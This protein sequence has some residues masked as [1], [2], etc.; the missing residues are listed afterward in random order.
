[1]SQ[2]LLSPITLNTLS[3]TLKA[4]L[5]IGLLGVSSISAAVATWQ[6]KNQ[7]EN[8]KTKEIL[9]PIKNVFTN[10]IPNFLNAEI[11]DGGK[12]IFKAYKDWKDKIPVEAFSTS[13]PVIDKLQKWRA[14][15]SSEIKTAINNSS[16]NT[17]LLEEINYYIFEIGNIILEII[18]HIQTILMDTLKQT[19]KSD[20]T[21]GLIS[22]QKIETIIKDSNF[23]QMSSS[24]AE[25]A[26]KLTET[27]SQINQEQIDTAVN[28]LK[29]L[30]QND[31]SS[32]LQNT[33]TNSEEIKNNQSDYENNPEEL[34]KVL[35]LGKDYSKNLKTNVESLINQVKQKKNQLKKKINDSSNAVDNLEK[36]LEGLKNKLQEKTTN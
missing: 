16:E 29:S 1:M 11:I 22:I 35:L 36:S 13:N 9:E 24:V 30:N 3:P 18:P 17:K 5:S 4:G 34:M 33:K 25:M 6:N 14:A 12:N 10:T 2:I 28:I 15:S 31:I 23:N 21:S 8:Q 7:G 19:Y 27:M 32:F 26:S 20:D